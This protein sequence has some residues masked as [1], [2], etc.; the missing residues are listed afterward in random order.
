[1]LNNHLKFWFCLRDLDYSFLERISC[2]LSLCQSKFIINFTSESGGHF[3]IMVENLVKIV[4]HALLVICNT[5]T[6]QMLKSPERVRRSGWQNSSIYFLNTYSFQW[7]CPTTKNQQVNGINETT[8][9]HFKMLNGNIYM[10]T[11]AALSQNLST[12][13]RIWIW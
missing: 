7:K 8:R 6:F 3:S 9:A 12:L 4:Y 1:M 2:L 13:Y 5:L 11:A 10:K